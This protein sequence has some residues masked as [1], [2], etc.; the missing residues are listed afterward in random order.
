MTPP[1]P[2]L[3]P[4]TIL[5]GFL[6][7]GKTTLLNHLL[8]SDHGRKL[9]VL[10]NDFGAI[11][12][13][14]QLVVGIEGE[15]INLSNG[16]I[17]CTIRDDLYAAARQLA[18]QAEPPE[19]IIVEA[20][21]VSDP[22]AVAH[23]FLVTD[24]VRYLRLDSVVA[25]VDV[26][27]ANEL[28]PELKDLAIAQIAVADMVILNKVD[29]SSPARVQRVRD[30]VV[31]L[32]PKARLIEAQHGRVPLPYILDVATADLERL[33]HHAPRDVHVHAAPTG[34][35]H[36]HEHEHDH[37]HHHHDHTL[38]FD[39][40]SYEEARPFAFKQLRPAL[41]NLPTNIYRAKGVLHIHEAPD[42]RCVLNIVGKR[43]QLR[44]AELWAEGEQP[45]T[46]LV[47]IGAAGGVDGHALH[48]L[49]EDC[50]ADHRP[51]MSKLN[52]AVEWVRSAW[53]LALS[54]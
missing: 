24:L 47:V 20:S 30:W 41:D 17:C 7:A 29:L 44:V 51:P 26:E 39:T 49:F 53:G 33:A 19:A 11:N 36:E 2:T 10:V 34:H 32:T 8:H 1:S 9:A 6:G 37:E 13:D 21:G 5:T 46:Q 50:L 43:V 16:C 15:T 52:T 28:P 3:I 48:H 35:D 18:E 45:R 54:R 22:A 42:R 14:T 23:T 25:V 4:V 27:Q 12:I 38:I 40:W 31:A